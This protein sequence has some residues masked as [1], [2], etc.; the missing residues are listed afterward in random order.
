MKAR[1]TLLAAS[2]LILT[3][4]ISVPTFLISSIDVPVDPKMVEHGNEFLSVAENFTIVALPDTQKYSESYPWIFDNQTQWVVSEAENMNVVFV[5]HEGDIVEWDELAQWQNANHSLSMLDDHV[6]WGVLPG[7]HDGA[8][9]GGSL[10]NYETFF[11]VARFSDESWYG[12]GHYGSNANNYEFFS[13]GGDDYLI[14]HFQYDSSDAVLAWANE[15]I[16]GYPNRKVIVTT[17]DYLE[18]DGSR[19][20]TGERIWSKFVAPHAD[21]VFLVLCGHNHGE[22]RRTDTV[23]GHVVYQLLANYQEVVNGGSG[24]LRILKFSP[25]EDKIY[26][27]TYSPY[28]NSYETDSDSQF[29]LY[30][31][32][33]ETIPDLNFKHIIVDDEE[34]AIVRSIA[35]VDGDG[36]SDIIAAKKAIGLTWY[37]YLNWEKYSI[38]SFNWQAE[39][40]ES[41]DIDGDGD[42]D[43]VGAQGDGDYEVY[44]FENPRPSGN[45]AEP[46]LRHYVG[47]SNDYVKDIDIADFNKD[48]K[49]DVVT[50][51]FDMTSVFLQD[52]APLGNGLSNGNFE[53]GTTTGW[54]I[55]KTGA[56]Q[57]TITVST[58]VP[59]GGGAYS[60][61]ETVTAFGSGDL[62]ALQSSFSGAAVAGKKLTA[63]FK[64]KTSD[65][66]SNFN[67]F[68]LGY[69]ETET[70]FYYMLPGGCAPTSTWTEKSFVT[71][72]LPTTLSSTR[73]P[74]IDFRLCS[75]GTLYIDD[76]AVVP[77]DATTPWNKVKTIGHHDIDGLDVGDLDVDGD[78]DLVLNGFW[79]ENPYPS[80]SDTWTEHN[81]DSKWWNQ[82]TS[83]WRNNNAKVS[84]TDINRD[85]HLDVLISQ[86]E[87][88]GYPVSWYETS[89]PK[90][91]PWV[92]H[93]I[94]YFDY[95][96]TLQA[97]DMDYDGD[98]DVVTGKFERS[99]PLLIP[100][101]YPLRV[102]YNVNGDG[103]SWNV[104]EVSDLGIY[105]GV[106]GDIGNDG[107]LDIV[108]SRSYWRGPVEIW[109]NTVN[110]VY[111]RAHGAISV[112]FDDG[113]QSNYDYA[114]PL[115]QA[116]GIVGTFYVVTDFISNFSNN[117]SFMSI[118]E[119]QTLQDYGCEI[120][121][122]S[123]S[124]LA[125]TQISDS[126]IHEECNVSKQVLQS[127]G[128]SAENFAYPYGDRNSHTD[129]I[130]AEYYRS[131]RLAYD[132]PYIMQLPISQFL[133][134]GCPG[135]TGDTDVLSYL[136]MIVDEVY[137]AN[138][139]AIIYFH[140]VIPGANNE[141]YTISA[142]DFEGFLD[143][144]IYKGVPTITVSQGLDLVHPPSSS[145]S[146]LI[147][148]TS[149]RM[150]IGQS[151]AFSS[152][153]SGGNPPFSY[154]WCLN[155]TA[156]LGANG[157]TWTFTPRTT[158]YYLIYLNVTDGLGYRVKSNVADVS[159][160]A[161][162]LVL[163]AELNQGSYS[164][165]QLVTLTVN[166]F[167]N[168][169]PALQSTLTLT[170]TGQY[171]YSYFDVHPINVSAGTVGEYS[172]TWAV[173]D[174]AG[175]YVVQVGLVPA[176]LTAYDE[177]WLKVI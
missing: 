120:A 76:V 31:D 157:L 83:D 153:V 28:L 66:A 169:N 20:A 173:A 97:G 152:S 130:V 133:L 123:K 117:P 112:A 19:S 34:G 109:E 77:E 104:T 160:S 162:Y 59:A 18:L 92:E 26:V 89:D 48:G 3:F 114:F 136:E 24:F 65:L 22:M 100:P 163:T 25:A 156:V 35:D 122:H 143:Y 172:F 93:V 177:L 13:G 56:A 170:I 155:G 167:N 107:D 145:P 142:E 45:P 73:E 110:A 30:F 4:I 165:G 63:S 64:Y 137:S 99:E 57:G 151:Q 50:R 14:F 39:D 124:H 147:S 12:G 72:A 54:S 102:C 98:I 108:G 116:R 128:F 87:K 150:H 171:G 38:Y 166:V 61:K 90:N 68:I 43:V 58:D 29:E 41:A 118:A 176:Q 52:T 33:S 80:L 174:V 37:K 86:S 16:E 8:E 70:L 129:S 141:N 47:I 15:T 115:M 36:F 138:G 106:I 85:S 84:V 5:T 78:L 74:W 154:H 53:S 103:L 164:K 11:G 51:S 113:K 82:E 168:L 161:V 32:M 119:L 105:T 49:L 71:G 40:I 158:G 88:P 95:C 135:E 23:N 21:Q 17:H 9:S 96:H 111:P 55:Y 44:W 6:P 91:G 81:I 60:G 134:A 7:N 132:W 101:P 67:V 140:D 144:V 146:V 94:G 46:W 126:Q 125:F 10:A 79:L 149:V 2:A 75:T 148:P 62:I 27:S 69:D 42:V 1:G 127:Y 175:T 121:S 131:A 139:W 159:V